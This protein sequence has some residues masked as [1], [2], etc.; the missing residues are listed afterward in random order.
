MKTLHHLLAAAVLIALFVLTITTCT[1]SS[2][3]GIIVSEAENSGGIETHIFQED[4]TKSVLISV[5]ID[6]YQHEERLRYAVSDAQGFAALFQSFGF[7]TVALF[8]R[9]ATKQN[10]MQLLQSEFQNAGPNDRIV[11]FFAGH[12]IDLVA[13]DGLTKGY[14]VPVNGKIKHPKTLIPLDW[15]QIDLLAEN[16]ARAKHILYIL[17][18]CSSGVIA[19]R[20]LIQVDDSL[21]GY[22]SELM[23]RRARQVITAGTA[24]QQVLDGGYKGH[25]IFTGLII[26]GMEQNWADM[27]NDFHIT[28]TELGLYLSQEVFNQSNGIQKPDFAKLIGTE[29]GDVVLKFPSDEELSMLH[30]SRIK[31]AASEKGSLL[32][33]LNPPKCKVSLFDMDNNLILTRTVFNG[34]LSISD[35]KPGD[36][37]ILVQAQDG[38]H[39]SV[40][41]ITGVY[42]NLKKKVE[43]PK[44]IHRLMIPMTL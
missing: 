44:K 39:D 32:L 10:I 27:N 31:S 18:A 43:L 38:N 41:I 8:N 33:Q 13:P 25:S 28:A 12:G 9:D 22:I 5:G 11:F 26:Q 30:G 2:K 19:T 3:R 37:Q 6:M 34:T 21:R 24:D 23:K 20:S 16:S 1:S 14:L 42:Q 35:L 29:G 17:D 36:Y 4:Y 7:R 15:F 40:K